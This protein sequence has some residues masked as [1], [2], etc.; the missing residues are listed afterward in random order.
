[1]RAQDTAKMEDTF[2]GGGV[3]ITLKKGKVETQDEE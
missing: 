2:G 3:D 1:M